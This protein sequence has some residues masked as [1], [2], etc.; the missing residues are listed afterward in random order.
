LNREQVPAWLSAGK[1]L[2]I[3]HTAL[4]PFVLDWSIKTCL[5]KVWNWSHGR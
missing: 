2:K 4:S 5:Q 3:S 1:G